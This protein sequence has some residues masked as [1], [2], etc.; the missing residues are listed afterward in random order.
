MQRTFSS[1]VAGLT[2]FGGVADSAA[3]VVTCRRIVRRAHRASED[4]GISNRDRQPR[5]IAPG[6]VNVRA[7]RGIDVARV[8]QDERTYRIVHAVVRPFYRL[9]TP[10]KV[11]GAEHLPRAVR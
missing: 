11:V 1:I 7:R 9:L 6:L 5:T 8:S 2:D 3:V 10:V 4:L